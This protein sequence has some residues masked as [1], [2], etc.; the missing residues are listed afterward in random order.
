MDYGGDTSSPGQA[1][2][3]YWCWRSAG[4]VPCLSRSLN[5]PHHLNLE[6]EMPQFDPVRK[7]QIAE[8]SGQLADMIN[9]TDAT[10]AT[11]PLQAVVDDLNQ[12]L[13]LRTQERDDAINARQTLVDSLAGASEQ[14]TAAHNAIGQLLAVLP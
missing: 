4:T 14:L 9:G 5:P 7:T 3:P 6:N 1:P 11:N 12:A 2:L 13:T 8:L 10:P